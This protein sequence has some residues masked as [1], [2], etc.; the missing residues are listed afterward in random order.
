[1]DGRDLV[2]EHFKFNAEQRLRSFNFFVLL[3]IFA[4]GGVFTALEKGFNPKLVFFS[5][6][7]QHYWRLCSGW[8]I[9]AAAS[10]FS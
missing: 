6:Y 10:S 5:A 2:W 3:S 9:R 7:S 1:M 4:D 8:P